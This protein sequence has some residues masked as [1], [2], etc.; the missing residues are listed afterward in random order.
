MLCVYGKKILGRCYE[1]LKFGLV[2]PCLFVDGKCQPREGMEL[3]PAAQ[4]IGSSHFV[5]LGS[6]PTLPCFFGCLLNKTWLSNWLHYPGKLR[7]GWPF[8]NVCG[9]PNDQT[10]SLL[11]N[12]WPCPGRRGKTT[13][14]SQYWD[15]NEQLASI[16]TG[17]SIIT[18]NCAN[19]YIQK[20]LTC[21]KGIKQ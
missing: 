16:K 11:W 8:Y 19:L 7:V 2:Y 14:Q 3:A 20:A 17:Y 13:P 4:H 5:V 21:E 15:V 9:I 6:C 18:T 12:K 1:W 10:I